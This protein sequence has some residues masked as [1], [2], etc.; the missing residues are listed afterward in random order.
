MS[1]LRDRVSNAVRGQPQ[2]ASRV[3]VAVESGLQT[4]IL[5]HAEAAAE[6]TDATWRATPAGRALLVGDRE[7]GST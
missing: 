7:V 5:E 3:S 4:L 2:Q 6:R 1:W